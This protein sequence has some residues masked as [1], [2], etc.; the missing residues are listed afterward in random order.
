MFHR[1]WATTGLAVN[2]DYETLEG[3]QAEVDLAFAIACLIKNI[4]EDV[5]FKFE[6]DRDSAKDIFLD[7]LIIVD[8]LPEQPKE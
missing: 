4:Y 3:A 6:M 5:V 7:A 1:V 8:H 2:M